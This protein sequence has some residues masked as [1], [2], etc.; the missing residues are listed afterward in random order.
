MRTPGEVQPLRSTILKRMI[1]QLLIVLSGSAV[2][3]LVS[4]GAARA[5]GDNLSGRVTAG[6]SAAPN[7]TV[8]ASPTGS[9]GGPSTTTD[10]DG[11]Y[12][13][14]LADGVYDI[15]FTPPAQSG[16]GV[17]SYTGFQLSG[18]AVLDVVLVPV[19]T[20]VTVSG[21]V[22][23]ADGSPGSYAD[24]IGVVFDDYQGRVADGGS[25]AVQTS[26]GSHSVCLGNQS[27]LSPLYGG[28]AFLFCALNRIT[29]DAQTPP[30]ALS[31]P[32]AGTVNITVVDQNNNP[33]P[34]AM[35][36]LTARGNPLPTLGANLGQTRLDYWDVRASTNTA[37]QATLN[38]FPGTFT[39]LVI[40]ADLRPVT[41]NATATAGTTNL[42]VRM[43][44][45]IDNTPPILNLPADLTAP[46]NGS[47]G[48]SVTYTVSA[49]DTGSGVADAPTC[50]PP[51]GSVFPL[52]TTVVTCTVSDQAGNSTSS[53]FRITVVQ[54]NQIAD[55]QPYL[56]CVSPGPNGTKTAHFGYSN[57]NPFTVGIPIGQQNDV[58]P[59][60]TDQGQPTELQPGNHPDA[61]AITFTGPTLRW[62]LGTKTTVVT[63]DSPTC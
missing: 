32:A 5:V 55:V 43:A 24:N 33:V 53:S 39:L 13:I 21:S 40:G 16:Y 10:S 38:A 51:S 46:S 42:L 15:V 25:F 57:P 14:P 54:A 22:V 30:L 18:S 23:R 31:L 11:R 28:S 45:T 37:G 36:T 12:S 26:T 47:G 52:G 56:Q 44:S 34:A 63:P 3:V 27:G 7:V 17:T 35:L 60:Q 58:S 6:G 4:P 19:S 59:G 20:S 41:I 1:V 8:V 9:T 2:V 62:R 48:E 50:Q 61:F 29:L 49:T